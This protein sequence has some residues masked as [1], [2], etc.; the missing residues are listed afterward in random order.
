MLTGD[1][2]SKEQHRPNRL[3]NENSPYLLQHAYN[4]VDWYPWGEEAFLKARTDDKPI[5]LSIGYSSCHWCHV[6]AHESFAD[7]DVAKFLNENFVCVKVDR[8]ERPDVDE[9]YMKAVM[10]MT[11]SGGWPLTVFLTPS[12]EPFFGGTY[13]PFTPKNGMP[14]FI[15]VAKSISGSWIAERNSIVESAA[16]VKKTLEEM[17]D[18]KKGS[19]SNLS[20]S[21]I[22]ECYANLATSFD[23]ENGGFGESPKFPT[24]SNLFF[25]M[26]YSTNKQS[27]MALSMVTKTIDSMLAGGIYDQVGGGFHRYS[28]DRY[29][30]VPHFEKML[31]DNALLTQIYCEAY[32]ITRKEEYARIVKETL[33]WA[34]REMQSPEGGFYSSED[35]DSAEGE[36]TYYLWNFEDLKRAFGANGS[37]MQDIIS[38]YFSITR[39]GNFEGEETILTLKSRQTIT[40]ELSM[41]EE[42]LERIIKESKPLMQEY[43]SK[44]PRPSTDDKILTSWNGLMISALSKASNT[45]EDSKYLKAAVA[46]ADLVL[47]KL[48][49]NDDGKIKLFR[50]YRKGEASGDGVLEDYSFFINGLI[51]LYEA[52]FEP[53][54]IKTAV[55]LCESMLEK[56]HDSNGG[57]FFLTKANTKNLIVRA[58]EAYDGATPSGNSVAA[59]ACCRLAEFTAREDLRNVAKGTFEVFWSMMSNQ[60]SS[61]TA[62]VSSLQFFIGRTKEIVISG[63][64]ESKDTK[65]LLKVLRSEFMPNSIS[66]FADKRLESLTTL[67]QDRISSH[68]AKARAFVCSN[69]NC[70]L[71]STTPD[72]LKIALRE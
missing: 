19:N 71:P 14:S 36:G 57:G 72:E 48:S 58:K 51:D 11:G 70:K 54:Y 50:S 35:A 2:V 31:Y 5:F 33:S 67:V 49:T 39:E 68:G 28:T 46:A 63:D 25:L 40:Q 30:L 60:P 41:S 64:P 29:W 47:R 56:F 43:R 21:V 1:D 22:D 23:R 45:I 4:P 24:P 27:N 26:R 62:M 37:A 3:I 69:F 65:E 9:V 6:M 7:E 66:L 38:R 10:S 13:F 59:L 34:L 12:L 55:S 42:E 8:E 16:Q 20:E 44:R 53:K 17:Y 52:S 32:L 61:F 18:V 15:N